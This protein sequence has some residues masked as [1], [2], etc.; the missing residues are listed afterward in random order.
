MNSP[1]QRIIVT[2]G[3]TNIGR[4]ITETFL[5]RGARVVIGQ[6]EPA[7]ARPLIERYG[8]RVA[9][10]PVDVG[11]PEQCRNFVDAAVAKLGGLDVLV[12]N[13]AITGP[14]VVGSLE[15]VRAAD[16]DR[17]VRVN[18]G[19]AVF[20][21]QAAAPH[22][23]AAGGGVIIHISS[24]NAIRPQRGA[25]LYA[26]T[27]AGVSSLAQSM[28]AELAADGIRVVAV[29]PGDIRTPESEQMA[30]GAPGSAP[31][32]SGEPGDVGEVVAFLCSP[33]AKYVTATTWLV[34]GGWIG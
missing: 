14:A 33:Q 23:R 29:A 13:A 16:F 28:G 26:A 12:N 17:L 11:D 19:G 10:L 2:G 24:V 8:E 18:L 30:G 21:S 22:L 25:M 31:L 6:P 4:A 1:D 7:V 5:K 27:K 3:A 34:D 20:C 32:G 15:G 9:A